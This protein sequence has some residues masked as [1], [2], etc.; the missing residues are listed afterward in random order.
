MTYLNQRGVLFKKYDMV[1]QL[2]QTAYKVWISQINSS[3]FVVGNG[4]WE[5][6][7]FV[8]NNHKISR[9]NIIGSVILKYQNDSGDYVTIT[10]DDGSS[11]IRAKVWKEDTRIL[12]KIN[13][14]DLI[15]LVGRVRKFN[16]EMYISPEIAKKLDDLSFAK[17]RLLELKKIYGEIKTKEDNSLVINEEKSYQEELIEDSSSINKRQKILSII[18]KLDSDNGVDIIEVINNSKF[19]L[20]EAQGILHELIRDGEIF[21]ISS[22]RIKLVK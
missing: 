6:N 7:Y 3:Q 17:L 22:N 12:N 9:V 16:E 4:E 2:R 1:T 15:L 21:E 5:A 19:P 11:N 18:E 13:V 14:G 8:V 20:S 10:I